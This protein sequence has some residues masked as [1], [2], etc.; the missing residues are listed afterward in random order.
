MAIMQSIFLVINLSNKKQI[1][2]T[3]IL[4]KIK[5]LLYQRII[6]LVLLEIMRL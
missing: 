1:T 5:L 3:T 2:F 4:L 6:I